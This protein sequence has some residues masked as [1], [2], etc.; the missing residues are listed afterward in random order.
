[1]P[2]ETYSALVWD[3]DGERKVES[4]VSKVV[5]YPK[6]GTSYEPG[7]AW[8]GVTSVNENPGGA[9]VT[10]LYADNIKYASLRAAETFGFTIEAYM[11]PDE[12]AECDGSA[13][14][15]TGVFLGQQTR[16][17]FGLCYRTEV[18]DDAHPGMD[19]GYKLHIV[20][21]STVSPS[22]R[23]YATI[24]NSPDAITFSW[25]ANSTPTNV[26]DTSYKP[27]CLITVDST[28]FTNKS[29]GELD[30]K[31]KALEALL[32]GTTTDAQNE[33]AGNAPTLP[34]PKEVL[35]TLG[36]TAAGNG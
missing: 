9:D 34:S 6:S 36:Y 17:S 32:Y 24:N 3:K 14:P 19:A 33:I 23:S 29:T 25:E 8:N 1:M 26:D 18:G 22:S 28:A 30:S 31:F 10:D 15:V 13:R 27:V 7:V 35:T 5:L 4:G 2:N 16:K 21:N 11:Y 12:W 20:Y